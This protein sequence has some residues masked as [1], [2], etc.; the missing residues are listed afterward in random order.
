MSSKS[1]LYY[2]SI[3]FRSDQ[4]VKSSLILWDNVYRIVPS[5]Y[6]PNDNRTIHELVDSDLIRNITLDSIDI[7]K[8][9]DSFLRFCKKLPFIPA[10]LE[11][12]DEDRIHPEK[13][14]QRLYPSLDNIAESF[15]H[16]GWLRLSNELA[17]GYMFH[18]AKSVAKRRNL[19]RGTDDSDSW[20][21]A[22]YFTEQAN[23]DE[24]MFN[25]DAQGFY[26][27]LLLKDLIP[28]NIGDVST[29]ELIAF[30]DKRKDLKN[31]LRLKIDQLCQ[32]LSS[33]ESLDQ[34]NYEVNDFIEQVEIEKAELRKSMDFCKSDFKASTISVG[35]PT[36]L[37]A[38]S[39]L[40]MQGDPFS[41]LKIAQSIFIAAI[42]SYADY[43][44][45]K[46]NGRDASY[47]SYLIQTDNLAR[48]ASPNRLTR[49]LEE[50]IND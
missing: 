12:S 13:I 31:E 30:V 37:T 16:D 48:A 18:L 5:T 38:L 45:T 20:S 36:S 28:N 46:K 9:G 33:I 6:K 17:R 22:P 29:R 4:W 14:D 27:T 11:V 19:V 10:G 49:N 32:S 39:L 7:K 1:I 41:I 21:I 47:A 50:F 34:V 43:S 15:L 26:C 3:E 24:Y 8:T 25:P 40:G 35:V 2:P 23:F 44:K 42:A